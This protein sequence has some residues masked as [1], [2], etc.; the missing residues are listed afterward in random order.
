MNEVQ[1][2]DPSTLEQLDPI[3]NSIIAVMNQLIKK[4]WNGACSIVRVNEA[5]G[6]IY[7]VTNFPIEVIKRNGWIESAKEVYQRIGYLVTEVGEGDDRYM[8]FRK[9]S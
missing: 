9:A 8:E 1:P 5:L 3:P 7:L 2:L 4:G 6:V